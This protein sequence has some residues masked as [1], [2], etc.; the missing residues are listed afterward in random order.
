MS[1]ISAHAPIH[2]VVLGGGTAGWMAALLLQKQLSDSNTQISLIESAQ[3]GTI[4]VG[5]GTTP[6]IRRFF[7]TLEIT[8]AEWM[9]ECQ[10]TYKCGI[11]FPGWSGTHLNDSYY[12]PFFSALDKK[13]G[14]AFFYNAN[15]RRRGTEAPARPED[16]FLAAYLSQAGKAPIAA[17][18]L[19]TE[20]DYAYHFDAGL[21]A[22]YLAKLASKRGIKHLDAKVT[23]VLCHPNGNINKL[24][25][26]SGQHITGDFFIDCSGFAAVLIQKTLKVPFIPFS[27]SLLN[28]AAIA[29]P[30]D[31]NTTLLLSHTNSEALSHGWM[32]QIP[33]Q[34]RQ[35]NGYVYSSQF[36]SADQAEA[37]LRQR[38]SVSDDINAK[39]LRMRV[40]RISEHWHANCLAVGLSQGFI[41]PLEATALMLVQY[42][43]ERFISGWKNQHS[44][45]Q[46]NNDINRLFDGVLDYVVA[47]YKTSKRTD[48]DY[49]RSASQGTS[50][51]DRLQQILMVWNTGKELEPLLTELHQELAYFRPSWYCLLAGM[52]CFPEQLALD[53]KGLS[54]PLVPAKNYL[55]SLANQFQDQRCYLQ[56][57][58]TQHT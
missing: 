52:Q 27:D 40:G 14:E 6:Y 44:K 11:R 32:W 21:L 18:A 17:T 16:Y 22:T 45:E 38:L 13:T 10:A 54:A 28:D 49:W 25:L 29:L 57:M 35:G 7:Q 53:N 43:L 56:R 1:L 31:N 34:H 12:H 33:L 8:E 50:C 48:T 26:A 24:I 42:T 9:P 30:T 47:H 20:I 41:E 19:P 23:D 5:E 58:R 37:E 36:I 2:F 51:S 4:G 55:Q 46:V 3:L 15:L 39:H